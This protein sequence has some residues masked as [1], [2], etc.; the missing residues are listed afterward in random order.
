MAISN[1]TIQAN[2]D[3]FIKVNTGGTD[4][5]FSAGGTFVGRGDPAAADKTDFITDGIYRDWDLSAI[6]PAGAKVVLLKGNIADDVSGSVFAV[7]KNGQTNEYN[8]SR[9]RTQVANLSFDMDMVVECDANRVVE[10]KATNT[11]W[12]YIGFSV[13]GWWT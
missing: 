12:T 6:V 13:S 9:I 8:A 10:Y 7:R 3:K 1:A 11:T 4:V 5:E 2:A